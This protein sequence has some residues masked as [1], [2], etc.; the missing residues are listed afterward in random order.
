MNVAWIMFLKK[1]RPN[2][3]P[4][5]SRIAVLYRIIPA[6]GKHVIAQYALA[7]GDE[8]VGVEEA[9]DC[10]IVIAAL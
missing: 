7:G 5:S 6:I 10:G 1:D 9:T 8:G 4:F 2:I 3:C